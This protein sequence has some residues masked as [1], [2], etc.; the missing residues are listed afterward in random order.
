MNKKVKISIYIIVIVCI[1]NLSYIL[2]IHFNNRSNENAA[3]TLYKEMI[4]VI[5][6]ENSELIENV[7]YISLDTRNIKDPLNGEVISEKGLNEILYYAKKYNVVVYRKNYDELL[8]EGLGN[9]T[10]LDG[11]LITIS[12]FSRSFNKG[13][14]YSKIY[15]GNLGSSMSKYYINYKNKFWEYKD[16]G[17]K[18]QS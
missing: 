8:N 5:V 9:E 3:I 2:I 4:D 11:C 14:I 10:K 1:I 16:S 7:K 12:L 6:S 18:V 13:T 17:E 15:F